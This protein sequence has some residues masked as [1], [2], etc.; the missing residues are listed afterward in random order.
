MSKKRASSASSP[1][2]R[3][4]PVILAV[5]ARLMTGVLG[6]SYVAHAS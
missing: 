3:S 1:A 6:S 5:N 2:T 4:P